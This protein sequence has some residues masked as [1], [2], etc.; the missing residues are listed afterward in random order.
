ME[1]ISS[2]SSSEPIFWFSLGP[3]YTQTIIKTKLCLLFLSLC[4]LLVVATVS[5]IEITIGVL[6]ISYYVLRYFFNYSRG[7]YVKTMY[8]FLCPLLTILRFS[9]LEN[10]HSVNF[11]LDIG[12]KC[13]YLYSST[14]SVVILAVLFLSSSPLR[15]RRRRSNHLTVFE[16]HH[17]RSWFC[18][19]TYPHFHIFFIDP[20]GRL[21]VVITIFAHFFCTSVLLSV[22]TS[23]LFK[24]SQSKTTFKRE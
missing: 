24:I 22:R 18:A 2:S 7:L 20:R 9:K 12:W 21:T 6:L 4:D 15:R 16:G 13:G 10:S 17:V 23:L 14:T 3:L 19:Q 11:S 5:C 1:S 8:Y